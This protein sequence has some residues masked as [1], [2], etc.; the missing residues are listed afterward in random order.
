MAYCSGDCSVPL[1]PSIFAS[2]KRIDPAMSLF[3]ICED[4]AAVKAGALPDKERALGNYDLRSGSLGH[5]QSLA[6]L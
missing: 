4:S 3:R 1:H 6:M 5:S 2:V